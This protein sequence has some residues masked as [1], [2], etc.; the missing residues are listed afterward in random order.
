MEYRPTVSVN[1]ETGRKDGAN[2]LP[3]DAVQGL[4]TSAPWVGVV[5]DGRL[6][7]QDVTVG[8]RAV[9]FVEILSGV[10]AGDAVVLSAAAD[11]VGGRVR[12]ATA[13]GG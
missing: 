8:L 5:R 3:E 6:V 9:G 7:R 4:G 13:S 1:V 10:E 11:D 2:V 12:V